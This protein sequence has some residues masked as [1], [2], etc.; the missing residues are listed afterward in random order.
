MIKISPS[1][2]S[3]DFCNL[4]FEV[5]SLEDAGAD[6]IHID[7]MD[8]HFVPNL[9]FGAPVIQSIKKHTNLPLDVHLMIASPEKYIADYA[10]AGSDI[11]TIH[12][13]TTIHL[14]RTINEIKKSGMKA[15]ISLLPTTS[16]NVIEYVIDVIDL[17][18]VMTV[19]PGFG[20]QKFIQSQLPK[21]ETIRSMIQDKDILLSVDG[22]IDDQTAKLSVDAG[23]N[24]LVSGN[25][26][27]KGVYE[28]QIN[29]LRNVGN[30]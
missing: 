27:F 10:E 20:G 7:V 12:P 21:I 23:A 1:I 15:G 17:I 30:S 13:E 2:L 8:G 26:I 29:I 5:K 22:G 18:L 3:A 4:E 14:D 16:T 9:T 11:L 6:M 19:N 25:F 24:M 28:D